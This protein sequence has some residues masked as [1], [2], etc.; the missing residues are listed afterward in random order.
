MLTGGFRMTHPRKIYRE[1]DSLKGF[2]I[3]LVVL[4]H[5]IIYFPVNLHDIGWCDVLFKML[6]GVHMPLFFT[7]SGLCFSYRGNYKDFLSKKVKRILVP[8][9]VFNLLDLVPRALL[10]QFVNQ[11]QSVTESLR[12][13]LLYGGAY[14]FLYTLFI[15]F[16]FYPAIYQW[17]AKSPRRAMVVTAVC[18]ALSLIRIP[19]EAFTIRLISG[20]LF[21]FQLGVQIKLSGV[22]IFELDLPKKHAPLPFAVAALWLLLLFSPLAGPL[23][24]IVSLLSVMV[25]FFLTRLK[26]FNDFFEGFGKFSLQIYLL[27]GFTLVV[28]RV[29]ICRFTADP[30]AII[31]FNMLVDLVIA[32]W[33]IKYICTRVKL[34]RLLMGIG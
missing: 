32:Y 21:F 28:S 11:S 25:C 15:I 3:F 4:G 27:N 20:Y 8:Y 29:I 30:F 1:I 16:A 6:S 18:L 22:R 12:D 9:F 31:G 26:L 14:W 23:E 33:G 2:A 10:P 34:F 5:A 17:Q 13:I 24:T 19:V 7:V